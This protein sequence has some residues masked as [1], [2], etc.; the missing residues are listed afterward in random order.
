MENKFYLTTP[1]YYT[2]SRPHIGSAYTTLAADI[3]ARWQKEQGKKVFFLT[4]TDEHGTKNAQKAKEAGVSPQEYVDKTSAY[5]RQAWQ[6][7]HIEYTNFIRTTS[8]EHKKAVQKALAYLWE[9]KYIYKGK[10]KGLYCPGCEQ[11]KTEKE[12]V[13][14]LCPDHKIKPL[15]LEEENY[16][17]RLSAFSE[18]IE[19]A[20]EKD[21]LLILPLKRKN[22]MLSFLRQNKLT[23]ISFSRKIS[24]GVP[25]PWDSSQTAYVWADAFLN[26][27][28]GLG[29]TG[30]PQ[31]PPAFWPADV[32]LIAK[33]ILRVHATIWPGILL[34]LGL[35]LPKKIFAHGFLLVD[36]Q[37]MSK[38]L[39][40]VISPED[41]INW[42]GA[43]AARY[44]LASAA[45]F[46]E[47]GDISK[48]KFNEKYNADLAHGLGN[49]IARSFSLAEKLKQAGLKLK[50]ASE[51]EKWPNNSAKF[52]YWQDY[53]KYF[54]DLALDKCLAV[55][56]SSYFPDKEKIPGLIKFLDEYITANQ[57]WRLIK[58]KDERAGEIIYFLLENIRHLALMLAPFMPITS[59]K[60]LA[61][62]S[63]LSPEEKRKRE[64][65]MLPEKNDWQKP[66][67]LF[68]KI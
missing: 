1:I 37:K 45:V 56:F 9:K 61:A 2:N 4:G 25:L 59:E 58:E 14:G 23:D 12:L 5:F 66:Q 68:P 57:P 7:L 51:K 67:I 18:K 34:A 16:I 60:I 21:E 50:K 44:L 64:W 38:S 24:W 20:I 10:Y 39:G 52:P 31:N 28:T 65:G 29:W 19:K 63:A 42:Y 6:D 35:P 17:F 27:L 40:N 46:G 55:I 11:F 48:E 30:D 54:A 13:N 32:H 47:D 49:L 15:V 3:I 43:E 41:L 36:G 62:F 26:Y 8:P 33:D 53:E 22:E